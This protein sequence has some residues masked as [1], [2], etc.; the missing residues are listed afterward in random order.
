MMRTRRR[1]FMESAVFVALA[2]AAWQF[3]RSVAL[4]LVA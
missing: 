3:A 4:V 1:R 2:M